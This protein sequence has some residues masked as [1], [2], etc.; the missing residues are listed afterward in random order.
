[1][2]L[3]SPPITDIRETVRRA[4]A[5]DVGPG[6][7]TTLATVPLTRQAEGAICAREAGVVCG[8]PVAREVFRQVDDS[9]AFKSL[10]RDGTEVAADTTVAEVRGA[11]T[12]VLTAE[13]TALNFLQHLS[14]IATL[15]RQFVGALGE[16]QARIVDTRKTAPGLRVLEKYAV[17][18][19]G[20][21]NHRQGLYDGVLLKDNHLAVAGGIK[22]A[23]QAARAAVPHTLRIEVEVTTLDELREAL[24][25]RADAIL[26]DNMSLEEMR[27]AVELTAGRALLEAS[28]RMSLERVREVARTGVDLISVGALT[29]SAPALDLSLEIRRTW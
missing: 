7:V 28:G 9:M 13:R 18:A 27:R 26:L 1:M 3:T 20:G 14:G 21:T 16:A 15:T 22:A 4:L 24:E 6:D 8:L 29:H 10:V 17:R 25:A 5:E 19:G 2:A 23:V 11:A 12:S